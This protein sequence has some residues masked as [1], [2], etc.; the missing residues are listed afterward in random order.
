MA[1]EQEAVDHRLLTGFYR[2][3]PKFRTGECSWSAFVQKFKTYCVA[4]GIQHEQA[5]KAGLFMSIESSAFETIK[6]YGPT[7]EPYSTMSF[8][9]YIQYLA[10]FFAPNSESDLKRSEFN[11]RKQ[12][13]KEGVISYLSSKYSLWL[14]SYAEASRS[15]ADFVE[16]AIAGLYSNVVKRQVNRLTPVSYADLLEKCTS[17]VA[18]ERRAYE[19]GYSDSVNLDGL[20]STNMDLA[21]HMY[22]TGE[23]PMDVSE[24][25]AVEQG[26]NCYWCQQTGHYKRDCRRYLK[27]LPKITNGGNQ[28]EGRGRSQVPGRQSGTQ[29]RWQNTGNQRKW[30]NKGQIGKKNV[31]QVETSEEEEDV[32]SNQDDQSEDEVGYIDLSQSVF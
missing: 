12:G 27:G 7:E 24:T 20:Q 32:A 2:G 13:A 19:R 10:E 26:N 23:A 6:L 9:R 31:N 25:G 1:E 5:W 11:A 3:T 21:Q 30:Q 14:E 4:S 29:R 18:A 22:M 15:V 17:V 28:N 16:I 8:D